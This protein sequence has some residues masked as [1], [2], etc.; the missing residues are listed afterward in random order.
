MC[1]FMIDSL[2]Y[3]GSIVWSTVSFNEHGVPQQKQK[4]LIQRFETK[5][6]FEDFIYNVVSASTMLYRDDN[7]TYV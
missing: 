5:N 1:W 3:K 2:L 4:E 7:F 6:Y